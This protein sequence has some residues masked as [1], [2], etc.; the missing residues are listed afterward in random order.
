MFTIKPYWKFGA[1][2]FDDER[3]NLLAEPLVGNI[4]M[5]V[6]RLLCEQF[7]MHPLDALNGKSVPPGKDKLTFKFGLEDLTPMVLSRNQLDFKLSFT[8]TADDSALK[9]DLLRTGA[10]GSDYYC[11]KYDLEGW[12]CPALFLYYPIAPKSLYAKVKFFS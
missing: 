12:L 1:W 5:M 10:N 2:V 6:D 11:S 3:V 7:K 8:D 9:L 4:N